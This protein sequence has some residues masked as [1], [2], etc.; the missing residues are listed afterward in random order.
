MEQL[1]GKRASNSGYLTIPSYCAVDPLPVS[2]SWGPCYPCVLDSWVQLWLF[3]SF[4][5]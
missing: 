5:E 2:I 1:A 4:E 3:E